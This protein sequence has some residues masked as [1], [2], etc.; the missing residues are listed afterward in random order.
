MAN[1][2]LI[3]LIDGHRHAHPQSSLCADPVLKVMADEGKQNK[4]KKR[5]RIHCAKEFRR[6]ATLP[7]VAKQ[8]QIPFQGRS[9]LLF[10]LR[11]ELQ[12]CSPY[13]CKRTQLI[14]AMIIDAIDECDKFIN[15]Q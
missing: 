13:S 14:T 5:Q 8:N 6:T 11:W 2:R 10:V 3:F 9:A 1:S 12:Y 15:E 7:H 4:G